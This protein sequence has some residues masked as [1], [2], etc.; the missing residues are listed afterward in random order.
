[1]YCFRTQLLA[2]VVVWITQASSVELV[3]YPERSSQ[4]CASLPKIKTSKP[5]QADQSSI[6]GANGFTCMRLIGQNV[7]FSPV[8]FLEI[9]YGRLYDKNV[10]TCDDPQ[11]DGST[12]LDLPFKDG[13]NFTIWWSSGS[14]E[15]RFVISA[16]IGPIIVAFNLKRDSPSQT[17]DSLF[18][19][20]AANCELL[21]DPGFF[22]IELS[23]A[24]YENDIS[25]RA[26]ITTYQSGVEA[27]FSR[28]GIRCM[29]PPSSGPNSNADWKYNFEDNLK[30]VTDNKKLHLEAKSQ[31]GL[32]H[33]S[34]DTYAVDYVNGIFTHT[35][36]LTL[37]TN[38]GDGL[39]SRY[40]EQVQCGP[41]CEWL[42]LSGCKFVAVPA[43]STPQP[44]EPVP[45]NYT[46][47]V[48]LPD[49]DY[50]C[51]SVSTYTSVCYSPPCVADDLVWFNS[52]N[53]SST[54]TLTLPACMDC[55]PTSL[56]TI[57]TY[58]VV[59][60]SDTIKETTNTVYFSG[61]LQRVMIPTP[62]PTTALPEEEES[63]VAVIILLVVLL[64]AVVGGMV[65][66]GLWYRH[67]K[68][69]NAEAAD[70]DKNDDFL[71][72]ELME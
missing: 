42:P 70:D 25:I 67:N 35:S 21:S 60:E 63:N 44:A 38:P 32:S 53:G 2:F 12:L 9:M 57:T 46:V 30:S 15:S 18:N 31:V 7:I 49:N 19:G 56:F 17:N 11:C 4:Y 8:D 36:Q 43:Y 47:T 45:D 71:M 24:M 10:T 1:M 34:T 66:L 62:E 61:K 41:P 55:N 20:T 68:K 58:S 69:K 50:T 5:I 51:C 39:C 6:E 64:L 3:W 23:V 27:Q 16:P 72:D 33:M 48:S 28:L 26:L 54:V 40:V 22:A 52:S 29:V 37:S 13:F 14:D 65:G 59:A